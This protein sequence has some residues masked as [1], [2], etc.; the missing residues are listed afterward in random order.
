MKLL[1]LGGTEFVGRHAVEA[2][3]AE[4]DEVTLFNRGV[5]N[6]GLFPTAGHLRGDR[7]AEG[8][9]AALEGGRWD[10][11]L[12]TCGYVPRVVRASA[13]LLASSVGH[14]TFISTCS[15]YADERTPGLDETAALAR[16]D[17]PTIEDVTAE[18]YGPLKALCEAEVQRVYGER[19]L[20]IRPG[21]VVGSHDPTDR[22]TYWPERVARGGDML[23]P[24]PDYRMQV[25]DARDLGAWTIRLIEGVVGDVFNAVGPEGILTLGDVIAAAREVS[26]SDAEALWADTEWL[27]EQGVDER[28]FPLWHPREEEAGIMAYST[29]KA[30][31]AGL[32]Y[33]PIE[34]TIRDIL[35]W[36]P[37]LPPDRGRRAG[38][39]PQRE[40]EL[41]AAWRELPTG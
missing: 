30:V 3:L 9:L 13:E 18:T 28:E 23:A 35:A 36:L 10:A 37:S 34:A 8:G 20:V 15:V 4:G 27:L 25:I 29:T 31:E 21:Y 39:S 17:D 33:R 5:T 14:Y 1:V 2:A 38:M 22:F 40:A 26:G 6:P 19:A 11:V 16:I 24:Q 32:S 12:D 7:D 41:L